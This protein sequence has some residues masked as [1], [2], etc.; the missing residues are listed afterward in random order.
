MKSTDVDFEVVNTTMTLAVPTQ[1]P[2]L[3]I[4]IYQALL[5]LLL[6]LTVPTQ[7]SFPVTSISD[8]MMW[9]QRYIPTGFNWNLTWADY[10]DGGMSA[11]C[12][13]ASTGT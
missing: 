5:V 11:G 8:W 2:F 4:S 3:V 9:M 13:A 7:G 1:G 12:T 6:V 10:R